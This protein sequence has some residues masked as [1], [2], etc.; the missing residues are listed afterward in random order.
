M[1]DHSTRAR[2]P[3]SEALEYHV[4]NITLLHRYLYPLRVEL[5]VSD[6]VLLCERG[7]GP[8]RTL[9]RLQRTRIIRAY[10]PT[11]QIRTSSQTGDLFSI[12]CLQVSCSDSHIARH[13]RRFMMRIMLPAGSLGNGS[14]HPYRPTSRRTISWD[15]F[16]QVMRTT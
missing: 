8:S 3:R 16:R 12:V 15:K 6:L 10:H 7:P 9:S 1:I 13:H 4:Q 11:I 14:V 5:V 2:P